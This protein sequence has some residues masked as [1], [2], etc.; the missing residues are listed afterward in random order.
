MTQ[1]RSVLIQRKYRSEEGS[2]TVLSIGSCLVI[3]C[4]TM[5]FAVIGQI[6]LQVRAVANSADLV[7]LA[8]ASGLQGNEV[9]VCPRAELVAKA[10]E[11]SLSVCE[12]AETSVIVE[13]ER[14]FRNQ[15]LAKT[16]GVTRV[17]AKAGF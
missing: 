4:F 12:V 10:N 7:A 11:T 16:F 2:I 1:Q 13:V 8:A 9:D 17:R 6:A 3:L 15:W 5:M 14:N